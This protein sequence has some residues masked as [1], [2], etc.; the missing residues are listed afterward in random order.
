M[1]TTIRFCTFLAALAFCAPASAQDLD[2]K[3]FNAES[4]TLDN[5]LQVV[6][7][8]NHRAPVV[9]QM[10]WYKTGAADEPRGKSGIAHFLE[11]L[12][13]KGS[14]NLGPGEFSEKVRSLGGNDNAFTSQDYTAYF[15]SIATDN[16][17]TVMEMEAGRMRGLNPPLEEVQSERKVILEERSQRI[18]NDPNARFAEQANT[19]LFVNHPYGTPVIGWKH[20]MEH[21]SWDDARNFYDRWY[22]PNNAILV[23]SGDVNATQI[24]QLA[25]RTYGTL[26]PVKVPPR[27]WT[28]SPPLEAET[29]VTL[30]H[31]AIRQP[32]VEQSWRVPSTR[33]NKPD[34]LA[35]QVLEEIVGN[36]PTS[37]L[38]K[39]LV[40][41]QKLASNASL[42]YRSDAW[43]DTSLDLYAT[44]L[45]GIALESVKNALTN[46]LRALIRNGVTAE[47]LADL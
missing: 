16:L 28:S 15:Q 10:V 19:A 12:M 39:S 21:L 40:I 33:Q 6:V 2:Q 1:R 11:H 36:G 38:Y 9:T 26:A 22:G 34:S 7:I 30:H 46:E 5:G 43:S 29:L 18:D 37:R 24:R 41:N 14:K 32:V 42:S 25:E 27:D 44:P 45:P 8:P 35:L 17:E 31:E 4:F 47:E 3:I 13:F 20:E 23:V